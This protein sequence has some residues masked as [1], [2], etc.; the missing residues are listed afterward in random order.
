MKMTLIKIR[1]FIGIMIIRN[2]LIHFFPVL[3]IIRSLI[4]ICRLL[5]SKI[6]AENNL[7]SASFRHNPYFNEYVDK[8]RCVHINSM[9]KLY[10]ANKYFRKIKK[11]VENKI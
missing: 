2:M 3:F 1:V 11:D 9:G 6:I 8:S 4:K 10:F 5:V 7:L